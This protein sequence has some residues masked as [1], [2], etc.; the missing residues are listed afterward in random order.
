[1]RPRVSAVVVAYRDG[2]VVQDS[3]AR[4]AAA[5]DRVQGETELV[6][7][8]NGLPLR[9]SSLP[10]ST[11]TVPGAPTLGFA[12][13]VAAGLRA[14]RGDWIALVNDDCAVEPG[15]LAELLALGE[16]HENV[17]SVAALVLFAGGGSTVNSAGLEVDDLGVAR[18]RAVGSA[19]SSVGSRPL[20]VFGASATLGLFRRAMLESVGGLDSSF[21]AYLEDADLAWRAQAAGW[22]CLIAPG[23]IGRHLHSSTLGHGSA[24]KHALV[25]QNRVRMLAKNASSRHLRRRLHRIVAYE[26]LYVAYAMAAGRTLAPLAGRLRGLAEWRAYRAAGAPT[27][28]DLALARSPGLRAALRRNRV[29]AQNAERAT[30]V[31]EP[32]AP[33]TPAAVG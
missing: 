17:G 10:A 31:H 15:A 23:A 18:E 19:A 8:A 20:D 5:L 27:R 21:F 12:G 4:L 26:V 3:L 11:V 30:A 2:A 32:Q 33:A 25:G 22:R 29:Y 16:S 7:V 24:R 28:G 6:V 9:M 1:V 13:G 14:A